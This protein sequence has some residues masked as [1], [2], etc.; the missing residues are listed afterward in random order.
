MVKS[1]QKKRNIVK[2]GVNNTY[3]VISLVLLNLSLV[4]MAMGLIISISILE[5]VYEI[6]KDGNYRIEKYENWTL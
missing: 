2:P 5:K 4:A 3:S 6:N 1:L